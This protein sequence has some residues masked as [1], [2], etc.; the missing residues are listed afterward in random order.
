MHGRPEGAGPAR[1]LGARSA[2]LPSH[3]G[4]QQSSRDR[5]LRGF[6]HPV[7]EI[8]DRSGFSLPG[9]T[10]FNG[11]AIGGATTPTDGSVDYGSALEYWDT[12]TNSWAPYTTGRWAWVAPWGWTWVDVAP[13]GFAPFHYGRWVPRG[14]YWAW[15]PGRYVA[16]PVYAPAL[17]GW[18]GGAAVRDGGG[19]FAQQGHAACQVGERVAGGSAVA[20]ATTSG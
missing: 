4:R 6:E 14:P 18:V 13:W 19:R 3:Q 12:G 5:G 15:S 1:G 16:R 11:T 10:F 20:A 17:V 9:G 8:T 2:V 7:F